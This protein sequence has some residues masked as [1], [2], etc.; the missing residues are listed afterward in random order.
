DAT[1][2]R[3]VQSCER[4]ADALDA[5][6]RARRLLSGLTV[7][8]LPDAEREALLTRVEARARQ[9][10][11][12]A[13]PAGEAFDDWDD[14][15]RPHYALM[16]LG[17]V[18][19]AGLGV[20]LGVLLSRGSGVSPLAGDSTVPLVT[21]APV[22]TVAPATGPASTAPSLSPTPRV[23]LITPSPTP[24]PTSSPTPSPTPT[25]SAEPL[26]LDLVPQSGPQE[27][28][29]TVNGTGF[30]PG[31]QVTVRYLER[32]SQNAGSTSVV[33]ADARGRFT[34]TVVAHDSGGLPGPH[35]VTAEDGLHSAQAT[36]TATS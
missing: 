21:A 16:L 8:A 34:T 19:A 12:A 7:V 2:R 30:T 15:R 33:V 36:F 23:F 20:G 4:C 24:T 22:L 31:A 14:E 6:E 10:L 13:V 9:L 28:E 18:A 17:V 5:Q 1:T 27:T 29:V 25:V 35:D 11:P 32:F 3:H 26:T